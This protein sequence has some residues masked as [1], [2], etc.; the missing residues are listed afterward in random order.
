MYYRRF[1]YHLCKSV[2]YINTLSITLV[3]LKQKRNVYLCQVLSRHC[4]LLL[5]RVISFCDVEM[6]HEISRLQTIK[7]AM[8]NEQKKGTDYKADMAQNQNVELVILMRHS[9]YPDR[10]RG[11]TRNIDLFFFT[12]NKT[13]DEGES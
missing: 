1:I 9:W 10:E 3:D 5:L 4:F 13:G 11:V 12:L 6:S 8:R 7:D 2:T